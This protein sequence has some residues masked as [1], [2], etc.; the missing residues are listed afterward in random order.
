MQKKLDQIFER[1]GRIEAAAMSPRPEATAP[2]QPRDQESPRAQESPRPHTER[3]TSDYPVSTY[4]VECGQEIWIQW[5][6]KKNKEYFTNNRT[7][8]RQDGPSFH[9]HDR[10]G[11]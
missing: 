11:Y 1:M 4:C 6:S 8:D 5:S 7:W 9:N 3:A 2:A 10:K